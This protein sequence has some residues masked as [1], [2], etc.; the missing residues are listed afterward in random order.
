MVLVNKQTKENNHASKNGYFFDMHACQF[1][2]PSVFIG[3]SKKDIWHQ[4]SYSLVKVLSI[5]FLLNKFIW[6]KFKLI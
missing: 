5:K 3:T 1:E 6:L 2:Y 4:E